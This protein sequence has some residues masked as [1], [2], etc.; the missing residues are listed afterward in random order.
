MRK[1]KPTLKEIAEEL[2][3][4]P[5]PPRGGATAVR[6]GGYNGAGEF[7]DPAG[8]LLIESQ[9]TVTPT[10]ALELARSGAVLAFEECG[11]GGRA[12]CSITWFGPDDVQTMAEAGLPAFVRGYGSPTWIDVWASSETTV[13]FAHGDVRWSDFMA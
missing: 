9:A 11:C 5:A 7:F 10:V 12:S 1:H 13:V 3:N 6:P 2:R 8:N 4:A